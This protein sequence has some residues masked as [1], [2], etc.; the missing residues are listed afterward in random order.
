[1]DIASMVKE[2]LGSAH[3]AQAAAALQ[4]QGFSPSQT[5]EML[6]H[7]AHAAGQHVEHHHGLLGDHA[8]RSFFAAFAAGIIKGDGIMGALGDGM[9]GVI[10]ARI[11]ESIADRMGID[12]NVAETAAAAAAPFLVS[13]LK[14]K[15]GR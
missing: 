3:G 2:F 5:Q 1:M 6:G 8:G 10:A 4:N 7:A 9:E 11:T 14:Q 12:S 13:F 15:L